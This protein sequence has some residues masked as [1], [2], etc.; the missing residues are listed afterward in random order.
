MG[1]GLLASRR[2]EPFLSV[3][4]GVPLPV[5][6]VFDRALEDLWVASLVV[7]TCCPPTPSPLVKCQLRPL[8]RKLQPEQGTEKGQK[9]KPVAQQPEPGSWGNRVTFSCAPGIWGQ[10]PDPSRG[11]LLFPFWLIHPCAIPEQPQGNCYSIRCGHL[12]N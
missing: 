12:L 8:E 3:H 11:R 5:N 7:L 9:H 6:S 1:R 10:P 4:L 2:C